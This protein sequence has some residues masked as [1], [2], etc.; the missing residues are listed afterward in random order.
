MKVYPYNLHSHTNFSDGSSHPEDYIKSAINAGIEVYGFSDHA[1]IPNIDCNWCIKPEMLKAYFKKTRKIQK[2]YEN[3]IKILVGLEAD[4]IPDIIKPSD[5]NAFKPDFLIGSVHF[6]KPQDKNT[7]VHIDNGFEKFED[8]MKTHFNGDIQLITKYYYSQIIDLIKS[9]GFQI[10]GH[11]D[12]I[13]VWIEKINPQILKTDWY[14]ELLK[15]V[16]VES[17]N[18]GLFIEIN[19]RGMY[20]GVTKEPYP[21][22]KFIEIL[23][24]YNVKMILNADTHIPDNIN[25]YYDVTLRQLEL[26]GVRN[27]EIFTKK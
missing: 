15:K 24:T 18:S 19:T 27:L 11:I 26:M 20:K 3:K 25:T 9:G 23:D 12:K 14:N 21:S 13:R 10:L 2:A 4:Y 8:G 17:F 5:F 1:P 16:A 6:L 22:W 7:L